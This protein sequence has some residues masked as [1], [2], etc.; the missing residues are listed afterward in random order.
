RE[1]RRSYEANLRMFDQ[2]RDMVGALFDL[3]RR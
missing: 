3:L 1:A 2:A